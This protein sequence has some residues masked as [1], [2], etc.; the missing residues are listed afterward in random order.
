MSDSVDCVWCTNEC[1]K[2]CV[3]TVERVL[4]K[5]PDVYAVGVGAGIGHMDEDG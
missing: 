4:A 1:V 3:M 2:W 5:L